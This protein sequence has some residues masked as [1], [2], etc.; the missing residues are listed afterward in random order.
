MTEIKEEEANDGK[1]K[2]KNKA[3][4]SKGMLTHRIHL[5]CV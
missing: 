4:T 2:E 3:V 5:S 1:S